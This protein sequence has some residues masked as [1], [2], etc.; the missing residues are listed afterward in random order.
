MFGRKS[1][2]YEIR[3]AEARKL[4]ALMKERRPFCF[5]RMG[6]N[7]LMYL[8]TY[9]AGEIHL[10]QK[11]IYAG[12]RVTGGTELEGNPG[13]G[14]DHAARLWKAYELADYVDFHEGN[15][16]N[17][18]LVKRL[19]L[20]KAPGTQRNPDVATS[21]AY[22]TWLE[23]EFKSYCSKRRI[24]FFGAEAAILERLVPT[25]EFKTATRDIWPEDA[26]VFFCQPRNN[27]RNLDGMIEVLK[28]D[29]REFCQT[30]NIDT[31][32]ISLGGAAKIVSYELSRELGTCF[33]DFGALTRA[34]VYAGCDGNRFARS[35]HNP[36]LYRLPFD[37]HMDA[38][39]KAIPDLRTNQLLAKAHGQVI[40]ELIQ[41]ERGWSH[42]GRELEFSAENLH[43][44]HRA[45]KSCESRY[46]QLWKRDKLAR[47]E[48]ANFLHFCGTHRLTWRGR[49]FLIWFKAKSFVAFLLGRNRT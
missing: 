32:F 46:R 10:L 41:K 48:R 12:S 21:L 19:N 14:P 3:L 35:P 7:E 9:Q 47:K 38:L 30:N 2:G 4:T 40:L 23:T 36:F 6:D 33:F 45:L 42:T 24:G 26:E 25:K 1:E 15:W 16:P 44:F 34:L 29:V 18:H 27:G 13:L 43:Y 22:F 5:L 8:L 11:E 20:R 37:V 28:Q 39:E 31:L 17:V 49:L